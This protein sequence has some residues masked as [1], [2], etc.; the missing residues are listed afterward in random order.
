MDN[1]KQIIFYIYNHQPQT[2]VEFDNFRREICS[3]L[4]MAQ[5]PNRDLLLAYQKL[6]KK[7]R[8][9]QNKQFEY[10]LKKAQIRT[11]SGIAVITSLTKPY[12]CPGNC[13][14]CP[15]EARMFLVGHALA[16]P[17]AG[18]VHGGSAGKARSSAANFGL[19]TIAGGRLRR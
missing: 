8:L 15:T 11:L 6:L 9:E 13:V 12:P 19:G 3:K 7:K 5:P 18:F 4:K 17:E 10:F 2:K 16:C 14:Y 1:L